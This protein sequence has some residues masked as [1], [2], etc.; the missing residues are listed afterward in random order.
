[1]DEYIPFY[2]QIT[3]KRDVHITDVRVQLAECEKMLTN[4]N[5]T[6]SKI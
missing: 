6:N 5:L 4:V 1:M 2:I 3:S